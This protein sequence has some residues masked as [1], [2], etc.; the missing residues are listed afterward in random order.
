MYKGSASGEIPNHGTV[1][2][3]LD[4]SLQSTDNCTDARICTG[5][6]FAHFRMSRV[7]RNRRSSEDPAR[8]SLLQGSE[9]RSV[10]PQ[11]P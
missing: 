3:L 9:H 7:E 10:A 4:N 11:R 6:E 8:K 5:P 2:L 1:I